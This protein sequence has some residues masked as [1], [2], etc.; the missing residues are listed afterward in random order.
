[1]FDSLFF[2]SALVGLLIAVP[3]GPVA[4]MVMRYS[5][6]QGTKAGLSMG[7][8]TAI[9]D[10]V[11]GVMVGVGMAYMNQFLHAISFWIHLVGGVSLV[12]WGVRGLITHTKS[13]TDAVTLQYDNPW[14]IASFAFVLTLASPST[15][16]LF[17]TV[18]ATLAG[19]TISSNEILSFSTG[20]FSGAFSW[21][22]LVSISLGFA[23][24]R[25]PKNWLVRISK[26]SSL[27]LIIFGISVLGYTLWKTISAP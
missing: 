22:M 16:I 14:M 12:I 20:V 23:R 6:V 19:P 4:L 27:I 11:M 8:G 2:Q 15:I 17:M 18:Y 3:V 25:L 13:S 26:F 5:L 1:M 7:F 10:T 9:A 21:W 24:R